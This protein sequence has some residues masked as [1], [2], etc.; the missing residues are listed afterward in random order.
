M[1]NT[2]IVILLIAENDFVM[3]FVPIDNKNKIF[4]TFFQKI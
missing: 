4:K 1:A 2:R 3:N